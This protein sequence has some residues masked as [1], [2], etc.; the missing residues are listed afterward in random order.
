M[1]VPA[2]VSQPPDVSGGVDTQRARLNL[3]PGSQ[4]TGGPASPAPFRWPL[5]ADVND[6]AGPGSGQ[7]GCP[8]LRQIRRGLVHDRSTPAVHDRSTR[9]RR[10]ALPARSRHLADDAPTMQHPTPIRALLVATAALAIG[11][12]ADPDQRG[13]RRGSGARQRAHRRGPRGAPGAV[14]R[15]RR[16][17]HREAQHRRHPGHRRRAR[18]RWPHRV[19]D[20]G[21]VPDR[22]QVLEGRVVGIGVVLDQRSS[23]PLIIS[24]IDGSP[25]S[26]AGLRAGDIIAAVD[27]HETAR[28]PLDELAERVRGD[29]G[30]DGAPGRRAA[31]PGR[32]QHHQHPP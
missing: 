16:A 23:A 27:D 1:V 4:V 22:A 30:T 24:V 13:R 8:R 32:A 2:T 21:G 7:V 17:H 15:R 5:R 10:R 11:L 3:R 9:T 14:R 25:A 6:R 26:R 20:R 12:G 18:R 31:W 29:P 19:S 28:L